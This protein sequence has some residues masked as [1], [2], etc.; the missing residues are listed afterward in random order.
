M[1]FKNKINHPNLVE[2][3]EK[4]DRSGK[5]ERERE[6]E[7]EAIEPE[8][9]QSFSPSSCR[10]CP[11]GALVVLPHRS[12]LVFFFLLKKIL[13]GFKLKERMKG[14]KNTRIERC[15]ETIKPLIG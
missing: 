7:R 14:K 3:R 10:P 2:R 6:R 5:E 9:L 12:I 15:G 8:P 11:D 13:C 4:R 1:T